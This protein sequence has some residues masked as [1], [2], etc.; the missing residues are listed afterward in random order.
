MAEVGPAAIDQRSLLVLLL[1][2][3]RA[4]GQ[5]SRF[6]PYVD[7]LPQQYGESVQPAVVQLCVLVQTVLLVD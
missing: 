7:M 5:A 1:V 2:L 3:E 4:K 6:A